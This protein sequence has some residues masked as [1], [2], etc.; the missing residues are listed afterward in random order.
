M[1]S[2]LL[3][4]TSPAASLKSGYLTMHFWFMTYKTPLPQ[5]CQ[6]HVAFF[7]IITSELISCRGGMRVKRPFDHFHVCYEYNLLKMAPCSISDPLSYGSYIFLHLSL[8]QIEMC[9]HVW[10]ILIFYRQCTPCSGVML[11]TTSGISVGTPAASFCEQNKLLSV[12]RFFWGE[13]F[14]QKATSGNPSTW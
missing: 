3:N 5:L 13:S 11:I 9:R 4:F 2:Y 12:W 14:I 8:Q 6:P 10:L 7:M 1:K